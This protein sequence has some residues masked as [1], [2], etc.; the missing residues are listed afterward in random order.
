MEFNLERDGVYDGNGEA[1]DLGVVVGAV[2]GGAIDEGDFVFEP[3]HDL[4]LLLGVLVDEAKIHK[5]L[6]KRSVFGRS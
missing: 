1:F 5:G 2:I 4:D 3:T 6:S